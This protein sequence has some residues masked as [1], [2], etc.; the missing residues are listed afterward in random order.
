MDRD[1]LLLNAWAGLT[2]SEIATALDMPAGTV[3]SR[4]EWTDQDL[5]GALYQLQSAS[6][7]TT[8]LGALPMARSALLKAADA[9]TTEPPRTLASDGKQRQTARRRRCRRPALIAAAVA[10]L[11]AGGLIIPTLRWGGRPVNTAVAAELNRAADATA[12]V[13]AAGGGVT[14]VGEF[15]ALLPSRAAER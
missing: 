1:I 9:T 7:A 11:V 10:V 14:P 8:T 6:R 2:P 12:R 4:S 3:R 15:R 5:D 13:A